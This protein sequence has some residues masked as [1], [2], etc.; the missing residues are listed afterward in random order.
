MRGW[1][2]RAVA[3]AQLAGDRSDLWPAG[4]LAWLAYAGWLPLLLVLAD[5]DPNGLAFLGASIYSSGAFPLNVLALSAAAVILITGLCA[6]AAT[7]EAAL[8][9][10]AAIAERSM[11]T[12]FRQGALTAFTIALAATLP[13]AV[14]VT[15]L[16]AGGVAVGQEVFTSSDIDTPLLL[17]LAG[18][19]LPYL[20]VLALAVLVGQAFGG[21]AIRRA[22]AAPDAAVGETLK[23]SV[24]WLVRRPSAL[25]VAFSGMLVDAAKVIFT[26][27]LLR[28]LWAP[29]ATRLADGRLAS[30]DTVLLLLGFVA[31][32]LALLLV[33]GAL[34]VAVSAFWAM[35]LAR[36]G[37]GEAQ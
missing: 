8:Q 26:F 31:I 10:D 34:H 18:P 23:S 33:A 28:I 29:I 25:G 37:R 19:L 4:A 6:V 5:P 24:R 11:Q 30:P 20:V 35:E 36:G 21:V 3:A 12:P 16:V 14:A 15:A 17:R 22:L 13:A 32:W 2:R 9:R 7:A 1:G 27:A